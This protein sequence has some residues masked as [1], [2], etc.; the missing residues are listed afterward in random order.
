M[1]GILIDKLFDSLDDWRNLPAYQ[2]E[3]RADIFFA[4]YLPE[5]LKKRTNSSIDFIIPEFPVRIGN[6]YNKPEKILTNPNLSF[7][8]DYLAICQSENKVFFVELKTDDSSRRDKQDWY[9]RE[10]KKK[11]IIN[12]VDGILDIN[13]ATQAKKKYGYLLSKLETMGWID[14]STNTNLSSNYDVTIVYIQP[15]R[16]EDDSDL[17]I[18]FSE[19]SEYLSEYT[20]PITKRFCKSLTRWT[21]NPNK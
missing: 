21:N 11:N 2:L 1:E 16:K 10:A 18:T 20:D 12:L 3:R 8:I 7:K 9:L 19:I 14:K 4:I 13:R 15:N 6:I 5:I 17:I